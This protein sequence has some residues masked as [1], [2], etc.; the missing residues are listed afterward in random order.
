GARVE[1]RRRHQVR[2]M[3]R[4]FALDDCALRILLVLARM[5]LDHFQALDNRAFLVPDDFDDL[6]ALALFG[7]GEDHHFIAFLDVEFPH[8][9]QMTSGASEMIFMNFFSRNS[10]AT[11]PKMRVPRGFL[12]ASMMT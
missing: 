6:A 7:A 10:R 5:A 4:A 11:G 12:S 1:S 2:N 9:N 8:N 3:N